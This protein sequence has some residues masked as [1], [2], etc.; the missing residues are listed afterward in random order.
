MNE[1]DNKLIEQFFREAAQQQVGD[2]GFSQRVMMAIS[3]EQAVSRKPKAHVQWLS[4]L[5][6]VFCI[7]AALV[8]FFLSQGWQVLVSYSSMLV[9]YI[10]V[11]LRT[12]PTFFDLSQLTTQPSM[13]ITMGEG[14]LALLVMMVLSIIAL[15]RWASQQV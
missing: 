1:N 6:T 10:E 5:W 2:N 7:A 14:L 3:V 15:T 9:T 8:V 11:F 4:C 13:L 12:A